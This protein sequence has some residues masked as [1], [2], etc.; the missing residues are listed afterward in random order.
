MICLAIHLQWVTSICGA[1]RLA[2]QDLLLPG[3]FQTNGAGAI[4]SLKSPSSQPAFC[5][6]ALPTRDSTCL[7]KTDQ[8]SPT[9]CAAGMF[10]LDSLNATHGIFGSYTPE[11]PAKLREMINQDYM[12]CES[13]LLCP[14]VCA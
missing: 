10:P 11:R 2:I 5:L 13:S 1:K 7:R 4:G 14:A 12:A 8:F 6:C 9:A 3:S